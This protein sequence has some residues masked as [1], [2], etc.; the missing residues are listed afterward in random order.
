MWECPE[1][2]SNQNC[3]NDNKFSPLPLRATLTLD[4]D[5]RDHCMNCLERFFYSPNSHHHNEE[6][7]IHSM[8]HPSAEYLMLTFSKKWDEVTQPI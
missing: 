1:K 3:H 2:H 6:W 4:M 7:M 5:T 8:T